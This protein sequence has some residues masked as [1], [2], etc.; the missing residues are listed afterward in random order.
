MNDAARFH[1]AMLNIYKTALSEEGYNATRF[2]RMVSEQGG[3]DAARALLHSATVSEGYVAL[4][5]RHRLDLT[6]EALVLQPQ[7]SPLFTPV[8]L[9]IARNRLA[10]YGYPDVT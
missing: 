6:V 5:E 7:W 8:E 9:E 1:D 2:L 3:L 10:K 4:W